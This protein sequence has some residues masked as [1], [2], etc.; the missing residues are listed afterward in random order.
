MTCEIGVTS[1]YK[2]QTSASQKQG[3]TVRKCGAPGKDDY[4]VNNYE[5]LYRYQKTLYWIFIF[6]LCRK[7]GDCL[8]RVVNQPQVSRHRCPILG[9]FTFLR[10]SNFFGCKKP[11]FVRRCAT[12]KLMVA[13]TP[14]SSFRP[15]ELLQPASYLHSAY[16]FKYIYTESQKFFLAI[17]QKRFSRQLESCSQQTSILIVWF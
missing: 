7:N 8:P 12:V 6:I 15:S 4:D 9:K 3:V 10:S 13:T 17:H 11:F 2:Q 5:G 16:P 14:E 1:C